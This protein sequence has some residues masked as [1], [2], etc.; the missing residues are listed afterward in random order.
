MIFKVC[1]ELIV[2][3]IE[4]SFKIIFQIVDINEVNALNSGQLS[5]QNMVD[6][7]S[8]ND[9]NCIADNNNIDTAYDDDDEPT[10]KEKLIMNGLKL[11]DILCVW[12]CCDCWMKL[13]SYVAFIVF[14]PFVELFITLCIVVN[15]LFMAL[16]HHDMDK[17]M[18]K[19]LRSGNY[20]RTDNTESQIS[21]FSPKNDNLNSS[22]EKIFFLPF[23][24]RLL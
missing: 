4:S 15:T 9:K 24:I 12:D 14:D 11:I 21:R 13:Q 16:D 10:L 18:E 7:F 20:V 6:V 8:D 5:E 19:A 17:N 2:F 1:S 3:K 22:F 23:L